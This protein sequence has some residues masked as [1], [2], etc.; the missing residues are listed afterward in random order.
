MVLGPIEGGVGTMHDR[1]G[2]VAGLAHGHADARS[3]LSQLSGG[4]GHDRFANRCGKQECIADGGHRLQNDDELIA[5]DSGGEVA[6][7]NSSLNRL[8]HINEQRVAGGVT[9]RVI[10]VLET[11]EIEKTEANFSVFIDC[12]CQTMVD[13]GNERSP[14][15]E[16]GEFIMSSA[17]GE[18]IDECLSIR[19]VARSNHNA[20]HGGLI[21][22]AYRH[23]FKEPI[24]ARLR[25]NPN[26]KWALTGDPGEYRNKPLGGRLT[27]VGMN[28]REHTIF[29][30]PLVGVAQHPLRRG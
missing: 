28:E 26:Q 2:R 6:R 29:V 15:W 10:D 23:G 8:R 30:L 1:R 3:K 27:I 25:S 21:E 11:V 16:R 24:L 7:T 9:K 18:L 17:K 19:D 5:P 4:A 14:I 20:P 12:A 13:M 22:Q